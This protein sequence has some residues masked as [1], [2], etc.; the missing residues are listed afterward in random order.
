MELASEF[1]EWDL[2]GEDEELVQSGFYD[3]QCELPDSRNYETV[4]YLLDHHWQCM[5]RAGVIKHLMLDAIRE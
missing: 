2:L 1:L 3:M 4:S 5:E